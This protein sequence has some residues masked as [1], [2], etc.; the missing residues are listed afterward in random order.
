[1]SNRH[2]RRADLRGSGPGQSLHSMMLWPMWVVL[3]ADIGQ[4][5][6]SHRMPQRLQPAA[7]GTNG[8]MM[9][10]HLPAR[11][12]PLKVPFRRKSRMTC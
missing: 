7:R 10:K 5:H 8:A 11:A 3:I 12:V 6:Q 2:E 4:R 9:R 1:M